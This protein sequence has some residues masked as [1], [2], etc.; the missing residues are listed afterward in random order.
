M[1]SLTQRRT[2]LELLEAVCR[3]RRHARVRLA[4]GPSGSCQATTRF[5]ALSREGIVL[6]WPVGGIGNLPAGGQMVDVFFEHDGQRL[7]FRTHTCGRGCWTLDDGDQLPV[8]TLKLPLCIRRWEPRHHFRVRLPS[9]A[10]TCTSVADDQRSFRAQ[11]RDI[12]PG[13]LQAVAPGDAAETVRPGELLWTRFQLPDQ[14]GAVEFVVRVAHTRPDRQRKS[15]IFGCKFCPGD[16][17]S[18]QWRQLARIQR[19]CLT[20]FGSGSD[21][22]KRSSDDGGA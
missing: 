10:A 13:G 21:E 17:A 4:P 5:V 19:F 20:H 12:A 3:Q 14:G 8:W 9:L 16:D 22:Q 6:E 2:Q 1:L 7:S 15:V 11:L 18:T